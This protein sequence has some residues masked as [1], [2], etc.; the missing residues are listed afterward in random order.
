MAWPYPAP[1]DD[2]G[3][4]HLTAGT[5]LPDVVLSATGGQR[6]SL[7]NIH[8]AFVVVIY[9][10]TG[11][12]GIAN[13]PGWDEIAGAHGSTPQLERLRDL[14][15]GFATRA[16]RIFALSTQDTTWQ[17]ELAARL[18]LP[19]PVISD[20]HLRFADALRLPRFQT[21]GLTL[22]KRLTLVCRDGAIERTI[23]PVHPPDEHATALLRLLDTG[24]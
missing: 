4:D 16:I 17:A 20:E 10:W 23:Y 14:A 19:F 21:G 11:R 9:P 5:R 2:G 24:A 1:T 6:L 3:A 7:A 8:G 12:Q 18:N 15:A 13:P 22:L